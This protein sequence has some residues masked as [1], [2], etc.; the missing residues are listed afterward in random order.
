LPN[1]PRAMNLNRRRVLAAAGAATFMLPLRACEPPENK[2]LV[3][4]AGIAGLAAARALHDRG[5]TVTVLEARSR[6]GGRI[7]TSRVWPD[8]PVDLGASWIH[9]VRGNPVTALARQ[10]GADLTATSYDRTRLYISPELSA[11]GITGSG[12]D[13]ARSVIKTAI[14]RAR[15]ADAD[16]SMRAA[17]DLVL[18]APKRTAEQAAQLEFYLAGTYEQEYAGVAA[19]LSAQTIEDDQIFAGED[20][21]FPGGYDQL[22]DHLARTLDVRRNSQVTHVRW[23]EGGVRVDLADGAQLSASRVI[24]TVPL[25]ALQAGA[26]GFTP[27]LP[28]DKQAA[29]ARL[30]MG[31]LNK[32]FL[33]FD[34]AFWAPDADWHECLKTEPGKWSQWVSLARPSQQPVLLGFTGASVA[35]AVE[36]LDDRAIIADAV[37]AL[38]GMFGAGTPEPVASQLTR[39][40]TEPL[41]NGSYSFNAVGSTGADRDVLARRE[42]GGVLCFAGEACSR[43]YPGTVHGA[44]LSGR[45]AA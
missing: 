33:R 27:D 8:V 16:L 36:A 3:I 23:D 4:G 38:R 39:W 18:P 25:G 26:I 32:H 22:T 1:L 5:E 37:A 28:A 21:L 29:I 20:Q 6:I 24:V 12:T 31:L 15:K 14:A 42:A 35:A 45:A 17:V 2:A 11:A 41:T 10:A 43:D 34:R 44:L 9:G 19:R 7:H 40:G 30:G 13:W